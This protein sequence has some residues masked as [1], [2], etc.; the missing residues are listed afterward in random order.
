MCIMCI[1][2]IWMVLIKMHCVLILSCLGMLNYM[3]KKI[4]DSFVI[5]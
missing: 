4:L 2:V 5:L 3:F 1:N